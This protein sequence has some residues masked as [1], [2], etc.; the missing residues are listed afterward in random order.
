MIFLLYFMSF[1]AR[2]IIV[3]PTWRRFK[4]VLSSRLLTLQNHILVNMLARN[5]IAILIIQKKLG[6]KIV[7]VLRADL[8]FKIINFSNFARLRRKYNSNN[9]SIPNIL[10]LN[11]KIPFYRDEVDLILTFFRCCFKCWLYL[12][13]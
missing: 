3:R 6:L 13:Y 12:L 8:F 11:I 2:I 10:I 4:P 9:I 7:D 5:L 1:L